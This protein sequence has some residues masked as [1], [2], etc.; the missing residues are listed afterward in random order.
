ML[1]NINT[2]TNFTELRCA[3]ILRST[4][5][6]FACSADLAVIALLNATD[7]QYVCCWYQDSQQQ[8]LLP[9]R[10]SRF[11]AHLHCWQSMNQLPVF[12]IAVKGG[13]AQNPNLQ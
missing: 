4:C 12:S 5:L 2:Y 10:F 13:D 6:F 8:L 9:S 1:V 11:N 7:R 3:V